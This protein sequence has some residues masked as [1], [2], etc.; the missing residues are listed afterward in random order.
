MT[1]NQDIKN[2]ISQLRSLG[3]VQYQIDS[4]VKEAVGTVALSNLKKEEQTELVEVLQEYVK[5]AVKCRQSLK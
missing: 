1:G 4:I 5:F 3:Y 2:L